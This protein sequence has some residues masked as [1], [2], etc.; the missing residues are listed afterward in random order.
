[1]KYYRLEP[2]K[3]YYYLN[4]ELVLVYYYENKAWGH[5]GYSHK[6]FN[7]LIKNKVAVEV[8]ELEVLVG[9]GEVYKSISCDR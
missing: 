9:C 4:K 6:M 8:S 1:M 7:A 2:T 3:F 5:S